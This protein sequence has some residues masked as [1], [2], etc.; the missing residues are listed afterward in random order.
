MV[1]TA[2]DLIAPIDISKQAENKKEKG[3]EVLDYTSGE[4]FYSYVTTITMHGVY[5]ARD[6]LKEETKLLEDALNAVYLSGV[7]EKVEGKEKDPEPYCYMTDEQQIL[8]QYMVTALDTDKAIG[9]LKKDLQEKGLWEDTVIVLFGDHNA[10]YHALSNYVKDIDDYDTERKFTDLYNVPLMIHDVDLK[11]KLGD[12]HTVDKF[13]CTADIVPT[14]LDLLGIKYYTNL[15]YG[16]STLSDKQSVLYS[17]AYDNFFSD[18]IVARSVNNVLYRHES[19]SDES[20]AAYKA[21]GAALVGKIRYCDY[22]FRQDYFAQ[23]GKQAMFE[24][25]MLAI[26]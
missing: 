23:E 5:Y 13:T 14:L 7:Y 20:L 3:V 4:S 9:N 12:K 8:F 19:V 1:Y 18:G 24:E 10:Y 2:R 17:R 15:Y 6:N 25:K 16:N 11:Q 21:E 26:N 22:I